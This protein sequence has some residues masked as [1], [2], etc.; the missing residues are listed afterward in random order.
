[1]TSKERLN[2]TLKFEE[3]DRPPHFE[4]TYELVEEAFAL[5]YPSEDEMNASTGL[6]REKLFAQCAEVYARTVERFKWDA[7]LV[8]RPAMRN[9]AQYEFIPFLKRYLG[10]DI[11]IICSFPLIFLRIGESS[12]NGQKRFLSVL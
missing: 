11:R 1:M 10:P 5:S 7:V 9:S 4:H 3:P 12:L 6:G 8:W 2:K